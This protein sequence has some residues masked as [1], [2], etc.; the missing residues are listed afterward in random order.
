MKE[1]LALESEAALRWCPMGSNRG[2]DSRIGPPPSGFLPNG[3]AACLGSGCMFWRW[4]PLTG[5]ERRD[6]SIQRGYCGAAGA[7]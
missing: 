7:P 5:E 2:G 3:D 1:N 6:G 4:V